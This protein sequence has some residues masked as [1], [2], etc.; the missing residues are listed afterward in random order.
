MSGRAQVA[1]QVKFTPKMKV[2]RGVIQWKPTFNDRSDVITN[3]LLF[4][5][6]CRSRPQS[7]DTH[8][9][10]KTREQSTEKKCRGHVY[11]AAIYGSGSSGRRD[12]LRKHRVPLVPYLDVCTSDPDL[13]ATFVSTG[14]NSLHSCPGAC[15]CDEDPLIHDETCAVMPHVLLT[16]AEVIILGARGPDLSGRLC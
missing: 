6:R 12:L 8:I 13:Q 11:R 3:Y 16:A 9:S 14:E 1:G 10:K 7:M 15:A 2:K 4:T 5:S